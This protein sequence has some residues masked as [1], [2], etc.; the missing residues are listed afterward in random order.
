MSAGKE[1]Q[2]IAEEAKSLNESIT[3][4]T[5]SISLAQ[6]EQKSITERI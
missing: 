6:D 2:K 4:I 3:E 5:Q 1:E